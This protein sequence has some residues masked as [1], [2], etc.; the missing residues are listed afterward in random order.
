MNEV[1]SSPDIFRSENYLVMDLETTNN[2]FGDAAEENSLLLAVWRY[3]GK[4]KYKWADHY[5]QDELVNDVLQADFIVAHNAKFELKWLKNCGVDLTK[6]IPFCTQIAEYVLYGNRSRL[7]DLGLGKVAPRY[8]VGSKDPYIDKMFKRGF[9]PSEL[10]RSLV[11]SRCIKD[12]YQT[13]CIFE[14]QRELLQERELLP[15][16]Y[17]RCL[18][19][20]CLADIEFNGMSLD[21]E[22]VQEEHHRVEQELNDVTRTINQVT[23]GINPNSPKQMAEFL[24]KTLG[25]KPLKD[26]AG[27]D[28]ISA[29]ADVLEKLKP[30]NKRQRR[31][32]ELKKHQSQLN[33]WLTKSL[34]PFKRCVDDNALL[35][36]QF[37]QTVTK[38][39]RLSSSGTVYSVQFQNL[40][41]VYKNMFKPRYD[42]WYVAEIDGAQLEFRVAAYCG[43]DPVAYHDII[44]DVDVHSVTSETITAAGQETDRQ[45]AKAHTFKP[46]TLAA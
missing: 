38:T 41:R 7:S 2:A 22:R 5:H 30:T 31:F 12:V 16:M 23:G 29:S 36:A 42:G 19:T 46:L 28:I 15:V 39:H 35:R 4:T 43:Q 14:R 25:F 3:Q 6:V 18:F 1:Y 10:P 32:L 20:P 44:N 13:H 24:Y 11:Q 21:H 40:P 37:N 17:T 8:G 9:C 33:A 34:R 45:D 26:R 27:N